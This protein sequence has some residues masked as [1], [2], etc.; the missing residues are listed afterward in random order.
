LATRRKE[1]LDSTY[2]KLREKYAVVVEP[3]QPQAE[4]ALAG[5]VVNAAQRQ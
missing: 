2:S 1:I 5:T 3:P 4:S